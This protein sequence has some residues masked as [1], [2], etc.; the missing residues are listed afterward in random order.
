[1]KSGGA[2]E[3]PGDEGEGEVDPDLHPLATL[4]MKNFDMTIKKLD[5]S[6]FLGDLE[7]NEVVH[8]LF[9]AD[10]GGQPRRSPR[11]VQ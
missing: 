11:F 9:G 3:E 8:L 5:K 1:V 4:H 6:W 10:E 7:Q 2:G